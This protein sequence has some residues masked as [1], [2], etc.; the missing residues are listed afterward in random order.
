MCLPTRIMLKL[1]KFQTL[2]H[3]YTLKKLHDCTICVQRMLLHHWSFF[4]SNSTRTRPINKVLCSFS[5]KFFVSTPLLLVY[6]CAG[7]PF[8]WSCSSNIKEHDSCV[9]HVFRSYSDWTLW[10]N[11]EKSLALSYL[12]LMGPPTRLRA[13]ASIFTKIPVKRHN[14]KVPANFFAM[15]I[16][17]FP[18]V[19]HVL[20][21]IQQISHGFRTW[22][23]GG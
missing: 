23:A 1:T 22:H 15:H 12:C 5:A 6:T 10:A 8:S 17:F 19:Y 9:P 3:H 11:G 21:C 2:R 18:A 13:G 7:C 20:V 14:F 16:I 4:V